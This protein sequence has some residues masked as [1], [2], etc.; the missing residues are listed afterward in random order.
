MHLVGV[1]A[2]RLIVSWQWNFK[3]LHYN[4][5][6]RSCALEGKVKDRFT[7][8]LIQRGSPCSSKKGGQSSNHLAHVERT[9]LR[10]QQMQEVQS[11]T[12]RWREGCKQSSLDWWNNL[13]ST[14]L[15]HRVGTV[16]FIFIFLC[17][18]IVEW[19]LISR[20]DLLGV[21]WRGWSFNSEVYS[22]DLFLWG[23]SCQ[24]LD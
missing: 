13:A 15:R 1:I 24:S 22:S 6:W 12:T 9:Y 10:S 2:I 8:S 18:W 11:N 16:D 7:S 14:A 3:H 20:R 17:W 19:T 5:A 23:L 4:F 21:K